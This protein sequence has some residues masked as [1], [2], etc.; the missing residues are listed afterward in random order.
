MR[1]EIGISIAVW[2]LS[3]AQCRE[4]FLG[5]CFGEAVME[6]SE[7]LVF[8]CLAAWTLISSLSDALKTAFWLGS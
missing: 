7:G 2:G 6:L 3:K 4:F 1:T 8:A 5:L